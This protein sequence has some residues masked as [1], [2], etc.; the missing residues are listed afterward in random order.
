VYW[1]DHIEED[2]T[3]GASGMYENKKIFIKGFGS[4]NAKEHD[5]V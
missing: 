3:D 4:K 1:G 2:Q 5:H